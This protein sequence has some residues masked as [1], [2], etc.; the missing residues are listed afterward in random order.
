MLINAFYNLFD[1]IATMISVSGPMAGNESGLCRFQAFCL[2]MYAS[3]TESR[4]SVRGLTEQV[5]RCRRALDACHD[6]RCCSRRL[7]PLR[8]RGAPQAGEDIL[9]NHHNIDLRSGT[10]LPLRA[11]CRKGP[12][13][14]RR[15]GW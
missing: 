15:D 10:R 5:S 12:I 9:W 4:E 14:R 11:Q 3:Y 2:Q 13:V 1:F 8:A 6:H 7:L